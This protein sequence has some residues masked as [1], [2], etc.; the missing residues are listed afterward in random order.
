MCPPA[1]Q[2]LDRL[3]FLQH[4]EVEPPALD[5]KKE[6]PVYYRIANHYK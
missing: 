1:V 5:D 2:H 4:L 6:K 3:S